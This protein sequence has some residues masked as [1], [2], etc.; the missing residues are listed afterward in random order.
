MLND[1]D[2]P[3][4]EEYQETALRLASQHGKSHA[5]QVCLA[6]NLASHSEAEEC[7]FTDNQLLQ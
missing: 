6:A 4:T 2:G 3:R 1:E 7:R 5:W